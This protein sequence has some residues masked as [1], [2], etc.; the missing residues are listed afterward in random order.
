MLEAGEF[1]DIDI[2]LMAHPS[3]ISQIGR[4][5]R[6]ITSLIIEYEGKQAHSAN[7]TNG[8]DALFQ[9]F[10][11]EVNTNG[12]IMEGGDADNN[13]PG[14]APLFSSD[15]QRIS[16]PR[17]TLWIMEKCAIPTELMTG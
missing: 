13:I 9:R 17:P 6:A 2:S 4:G 12:I 8:V 3:A 14:Y 16:P 11:R 10:P 7:P 1:N 15:G 5:G